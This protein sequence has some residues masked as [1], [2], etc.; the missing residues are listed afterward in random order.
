MLG[1]TTETMGPM[2]KDMRHNIIYTVHMHTT[3]MSALMMRH[4][5]ISQVMH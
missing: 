2:E 4:S 1:P 3:S 5:A